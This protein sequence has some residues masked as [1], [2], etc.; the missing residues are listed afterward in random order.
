MD[1]QDGEDFF[2]FVLIQGLSSWFLDVK[3]ALEMSFKN[4][5]FNINYLTASTMQYNKEIM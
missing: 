4:I 1:K 5:N 2:R 3:H